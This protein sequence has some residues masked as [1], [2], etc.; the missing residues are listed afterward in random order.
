MSAATS[1]HTTLEL[2]GLVFSIQSLLRLCN[3]DTCTV[4]R[5]VSLLPAS[6]DANMEAEKY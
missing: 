3:E 4:I 1:K 2:L 5:V 6:K